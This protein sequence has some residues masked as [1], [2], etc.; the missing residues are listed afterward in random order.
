[1]V[2]GAGADE[3]AAA[4]PLLLADEGVDLVIA[5]FVPP[6][7]VDPVRVARAIFDASRGAKKPVL[8]C[9]MARDAVI[10]EIKRLESAW[11]PLYDYPEEAVRAAAA[12]LRI[13]RLRD[14]DVGDPAPRRVDAG[15]AARIV[16]DARSERRRA[17]RRRRRLRSARRVR[18]PRPGLSRREDG[19][20]GDGRGGEDRLPR[21]REAR[22]AR[23]RPQDGR[24]RRGARP[25]GPR[26]GARGDGEAVGR[27]GAGRAGLALP[28]PRAAH[29]AGGRRAGPRRPHRP[30]V[31]PARDGGPRRSTS[32]S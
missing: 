12:L 30:R 4:L 20:G 18:G 17:P 2:A 24:R 9:F 22:R 28:L 5:I 23:V 10:E 8:G 1:M 15:E 21:G 26:R 14:D 31:R 6:I 29:G 25:R 16:G 13:R 19:G 11:F 32:R 27:R 7:T 3:Y